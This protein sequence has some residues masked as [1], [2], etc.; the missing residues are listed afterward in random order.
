MK[1]DTIILTFASP[2]QKEDFLKATKIEES[3]IFTNEDLSLQIPVYFTAE[4]EDSELVQN[5]ADGEPVEVE[6]EDFDLDEV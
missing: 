4:A 2:D 1:Q 6:D 3:S 5:V